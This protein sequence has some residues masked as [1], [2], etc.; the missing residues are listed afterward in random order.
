[1]NFKGYR[2]KVKE[3]C[4]VKIKKKMDC[5]LLVSKGEELLSYL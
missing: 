1:M 3:I 5:W 2:V 4:D